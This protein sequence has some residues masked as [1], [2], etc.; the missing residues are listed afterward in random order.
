MP[1][2]HKKPSWHSLQLV[3]CPSGNTRL[4][5]SVWPSKLQKNPDG[6]GLHVK[7]EFEPSKSCMCHVDNLGSVFSCHSD[8]SKPFGKSHSDCRFVVIA[9]SWAGFTYFAPVDML[10]LPV[11]Q[12]TGVDAPARGT[13]VPDCRRWIRRSPRTKCSCRT[14]ATSLSRTSILSIYLIGYR[15]CAL[16]DIN[17][18]RVGKNT[19]VCTVQPTASLFFTIVFVCKN[20]GKQN[21]PFG[22]G[23]AL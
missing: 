21:V 16:L 4:K 22:Q 1:A 11:G 5:Q 8:N 12:S 10:N 14:K 23:M 17:L 18:H 2:G 15:I 20:P 19:L 9:A 3:V 7:E 6:V 13:C